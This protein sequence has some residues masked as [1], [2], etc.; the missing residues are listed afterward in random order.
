MTDELK[1]TYL[2]FL[3]PS[4]L[5]FTLA[6]G[7]KAYDLIEIG[8]DNFIQI[9]GPLIF[10][11]CIALAIAFPI[12]YRALFAHKNRDVMSVSDQK[13]LKFERTLVNVVMI[14][15][16]LALL[17]YLFELP[18]FYTGSAILIGLYAVYY[19]Y[20]SKKRIAFERRIFRV[21]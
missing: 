12:F 20:P 14:T 7:A 2:T 5:G 11:L 3:L 18:R 4:I 16:Y 9:G 10:I 13:F 1:R 17:S 8:S 15:P 21:K 6:G 19:F